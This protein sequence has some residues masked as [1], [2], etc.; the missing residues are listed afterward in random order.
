MNEETTHDDKWQPD[1]TTGGRN[2]QRPLTIGD[3]YGMY[4]VRQGWECPRCKRINNP[5]LQQCLC[6][7]PTFAY[8]SSYGN[9]AG[10]EFV[11]HSPLGEGEGF[12]ELAF[13]TKKGSWDGR[14]HGLGGPIDFMNEE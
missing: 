5:D 10:E 9:S 12:S 2:Y 4:M 13:V 14:W 11:Q 3:P 7:P 8:I 6:G 1:D